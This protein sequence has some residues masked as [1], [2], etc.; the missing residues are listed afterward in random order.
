MHAGL[1]RGVSRCMAVG[2]HLGDTGGRSLGGLNAM[3]AVAI[4]T[5]RRLHIPVSVALGMHAMCGGFIL[6]FVTGAAGLVQLD[7][8]RTS[9]GIRHVGNDLSIW[10]GRGM[11][12]RTSHLLDTLVRITR[13]RRVAGCASQAGLSMHRLAELLFRDGQAGCRQVLSLADQVWIDV[14]HRTA[15]VPLSKI[16]LVAANGNR[17]RLWGGEGFTWGCLSLMGNMAISAGLRQ[18][19]G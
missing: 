11:A 14:A 7:A 19:I 2:A 1:V 13:D 15:A 17:G 5:Q 4:Y 10:L 18:W 12:C 8:H 6:V 3:A 16:R 9:A